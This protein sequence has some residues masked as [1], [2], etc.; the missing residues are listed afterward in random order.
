MI[1]H[2]SYI[3]SIQSPN[4]FLLVGFL[5]RLLGNRVWP[6]R[7]VHSRC[8][9]LESKRCYG[10]SNVKVRLYSLLFEICCMDLFSVIEKKQL[11]PNYKI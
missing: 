11:T 8:N 9:T 10:N 5:C 6:V 2:N 4:L 7:G 1:F 3:S